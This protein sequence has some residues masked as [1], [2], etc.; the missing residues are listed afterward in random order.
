MERLLNA[1]PRIRQSKLFQNRRTHVAPPKRPIM[2][3]ITKPIA[4]TA[5]SGGTRFLK[6]LSRIFTREVKEMKFTGNDKDHLFSVS[7]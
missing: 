2:N 3:K 7:K 1:F 6:A 5:E 4:E